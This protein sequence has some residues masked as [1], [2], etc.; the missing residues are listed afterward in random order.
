MVFITK[1]GK[2]FL[3][4]ILGMDVD[5]PEVRKYLFKMDSLTLITLDAVVKDVIEKNKNPKKAE[6]IKTSKIDLAW[7]KTGENFDD[8]K[9]V[10]VKQLTKYVT[11]DL[12][13]KILGEDDLLGEYTCTDSLIGKGMRSTTLFPM[14]DPIVYFDSEEDA[15]A[16]M[17]E[18][19]LAQGMANPL[20]YNEQ[21]FDMVSDASFSRIFFFG[22]GCPLVQD[23]TSTSAEL[24]PFVV[25]MPLQ[26]LQVR[27]GF[28]KYG[29]R[30]HF[31]S[32]QEVT[33][34]FDYTKN[35]LV[36]PK[37]D[38][39]EWEEAKFLSK[40]SCFTLV[41][42]REHLVWSHLLLSNTATREKTLCL[43]PSHPIRRLLTIFTFGSTEVNQNAFDA[44]VPETCLLHRALGLKYSSMQAVFDSAFKESIVYEPY[45]DRKVDPG[46]KKLSDEGKFP[47]ISEGVA[48]FEIVRTFVKK[49]MAKAGD[50]CKDEHALEF[51]NAMRKASK[52]QKYE[53]PEHS[54]ENMANLC[55]QII[56]TVTAFHE[57]VG[58]VTDY[59]G[60][61]PNRAGFR[62]C[63]GKTE[64]D[65]QSFIIA[66]CIGAST[67]VRMPV[68]MSKFE[69]FFGVGGAPEWE[70]EHWEAFR[71]D[72][73]KQSQAVKAAD[74]KREVEF[75]YFDP[76]RFECSIS[77]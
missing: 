37:D 39:K 77:V 65:I 3:M 47:Y 33:G 75:K 34:I 8:W 23:A 73:A 9:K 56:F 10:A 43:P 63:R 48:Y 36:T 4:S 57:L 24:G 62:S 27:K 13:I 11:P 64:V 41:T 70:R 61:L 32:A 30:I 69:N 53:I 19:E 59:V 40:I 35:K 15:A 20:S 68:L 7:K 22:I 71:S 42:A 67:S 28:M 66:S 21:V 50:A 51:Y 52:G 44:L 12:S 25:D 49:W 16:F 17:K 1:L 29:A 26:D 74:A 55:A 45:A 6:D 46:L 31:N 18:T 54:D 5:D 58:A 2:K 14:K 72:L 38:E 60:V 76:A